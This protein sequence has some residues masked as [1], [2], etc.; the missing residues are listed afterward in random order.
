MATLPLRSHV[1]K[2]CAKDTIMWLPAHLCSHILQNFN[3]N[4]HCP[5]YNVVNCAKEK[6][7]YQEVK[8][9]W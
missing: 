6:V 9:E 7:N 2:F 5:E 4:M 3:I 1:L 8:R